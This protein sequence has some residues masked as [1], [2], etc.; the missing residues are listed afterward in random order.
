MSGWK[1]T[2]AA[3]FIV[4]YVG[5]LSSGIVSHALKVGLCGNT[6]SYFVVWDMFCGW[7]AWDKRTHII[8]EDASGD[9]YEV[10]APWGEFEPFG[11]VARVQYDNTRHLTPKHI[12][13]VLQHSLHEEIAKVFVIE[14][15]W[16]KQYNL[17]PK[18]FA[19]HFDRPHDKQSYF[20]LRAVCDDHGFPITVNPDWY[21]QQ[22]LNAVYDNPRLQRQSNQA[23]AI[24]STFYNPAQN[25][26]A[27]SLSASSSTGLSTN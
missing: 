1:K 5:W 23:T 24:Y 17:P 20:H 3:C 19:Y 21:D 11:H 9:F 8:A 22:R 27:N 2:A 18:L 7:T 6:L 4:L 13:N 26:A 14:E 12:D 16:P 15:V 10:R 25:A